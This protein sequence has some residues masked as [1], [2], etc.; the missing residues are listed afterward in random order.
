M[1]VGRLISWLESAPAQFRAEAAHALAKLWLEPDIDPDELDAAEAAMT[2]L[3]DDPAMEVRLALASAL[4]PLHNAPRHIILALAG[5]A[6]SL[7]SIVLSQSTVFLDD[8]LV[9]I[10]RAGASPQHAALASREPLSANVAFA[11]CEHGDAQACL[12][13]LTNPAALV[14]AEALHRIGERHGENT[15]MRRLLLANQNLM[16]ATRLL[17]INKVGDAL[18]AELA[19]T[20]GLSPL[21]LEQMLAD[22]AEKAI[23]AY[24]SKTEETEL[25]QIV[26]ALVETGKMTAAF[27][28]RSICMGNIELFATAI[29]QLSSVPVGRVEAAMQLNRRSAFRALYLK[30]E[31]PQAAF[32]VFAGAIEIWRKLLCTQ[33]GADS[34]RLTWM[35]TRELL[36]SYRGR[37]DN[38]TD[39]LLVL[40]RRLGSEAAHRNA[41]SHAGR[42]AADVREQEQ[43]LGDLR[44][45][46][47]QAAI[48]EAFPVVDVPFADITGFALHFA[49]ELVD[50]ETRLEQSGTDAGD[51]HLTG[52]GL[53][54]I[55]EPLSHA[56][57]A[58]DDF[59]AGDWPAPRPNHLAVNLGEATIRAA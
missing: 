50:L 42:L 26:A 11:V 14:P 57:A 2:L 32:E 49:E 4:A 37:S 55:Y 7:A 59:N 23:I 58:N 34:T 17:L 18:R 43:M 53:P 8:E 21:R 51:L 3:L 10:A 27:L 24:A 38:A 46:E 41:R 22:H 52:P 47:L 31:L 20:P 9:E 6:A 12:V 15:V 44:E 30:C 40:L 33:H 28:L 1:I 13:L 16:P 56:D 25:P 19:G 48:L 5:E 54:A 45:A 29:A 36:S 39:A 35:V